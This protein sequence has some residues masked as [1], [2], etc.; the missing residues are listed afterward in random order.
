MMLF[1][2]VER[3]LKVAQNTTSPIRKFFISPDEAG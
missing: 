3:L 2:H 1:A